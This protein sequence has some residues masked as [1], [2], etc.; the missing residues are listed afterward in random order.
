MMKR[1]LISI[2]IM[3]LVGCASSYAD[4]VITISP[5]SG[6]LTGTFPDTI[7]WNFSV[8]NSNTADS[9]FLLNQPFV[10]RVSLI[11]ARKVRPN[12]LG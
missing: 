3:L 2:V 12:L 10:C 9:S 11:P 8:D 7:S 4:V 1:L 6:S 5:P